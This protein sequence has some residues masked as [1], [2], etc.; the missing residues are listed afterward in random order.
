MNALLQLQAIYNKKSGSF[1]KMFK[2]V[3]FFFPLRIIGRGLYLLLCIDTVVGE[4]TFHEEPNVKSFWPKYRDSMAFVA[5]DPAAYG[6]DPEKMKLL[7]RVIIKV[8]KGVM[9]ADTLNTFLNHLSKESNMNI[10]EEMTDFN[11]IRN[12]KYILE[13]LKNYFKTCQSNMEAIFS[14]PLA[15][16]LDDS[17]KLGEYLCV[18]AFYIKFFKQDNKEVWRNIWSLQ[19]KVLMI[20][21][22]K[23]SMIRI[24]DFL[25]KYCPPKKMYSSL[26]PKDINSY[27]T[28]CIKKSQETLKSDVV[29]IYKFLCQWCLKMNSMSCSM[30]VFQNAKEIDRTKIFEMRMNQILSGISC[31]NRLKTL[32]HNNFLIRTK[33]GYKTVPEMNKPLLLIIE[34]CKKMQEMME[35]K[36]IQMMQ[37]MMIKFNCLKISK[38]I[39]EYCGRVQNSK[40]SDK[41]FFFEAFKKLFYLV[42]ATPV[43]QRDQLQDYCLTFIG[44]KNIIKDP[45]ILQF[46]KLLQDHRA[47]C[48]Y[49]S[50][51]R[52]VLDCSFIY[53]FREIIPDLLQL[54]TN[55]DGEY[56]RLQT[57]INSFG[58]AAVLLKK[59]VHLQDNSLLSNGFRDYIIG[60]ISSKI[61][62]K[63]SQM[64]EENLLIQ[65]HHFYT[66]SDLEKPKTQDSFQGDIRSFLAVEKLTVFDKTFNLKNLI[67]LSLS[68][69]L[70]NR[71]SDNQ[72]NFDTYEI[73]R[74]LAK[75]K[76]N[77]ELDHSYI[78]S[79]TV[80]QGR[81]DV[82]TI[83]RSFK[84]FILNFKY[85]MFNQ[86]FIE[87]LKDST[88]LKAVSI[89][90]ISDSIKTHGLGII[91]GSIQHVADFIHQ[92]V[93][94]TL[95]R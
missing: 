33:L 17:E 30:Y 81:T 34:M 48:N 78:P 44:V 9:T 70:Y 41:T 19:K 21:T 62:K 35:Q 16:H 40:M 86:T 45:E 43:E 22:H 10:F 65:T 75:T 74:S 64:I 50:I 61:V 76:F 39:K 73:M 71:I 24:C 5:N 56:F 29:S 46:K 58:D 36:D 69:S 42:S 88:R 38:V 26:E 60:E 3:D 8:D 87:T 80:E 95:D 12:N 72:K 6:L 37:E 55:S 54:K 68:E 11:S 31:A 52:E 91:K 84:P 25:M 92:Y 67:E 51:Y 66:I 49:K 7:R 94:L 47:L 28:E 27:T 82:L 59:A 77:L 89:N 63:S 57:L 32:I 90:L 4:S 83:I 2:E 93:M 1:Y 18:F 53:W 23:F 13:L 79:K 15:L 85:N 20:N 14:D